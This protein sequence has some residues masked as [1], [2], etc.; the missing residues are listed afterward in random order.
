MLNIA[1]IYLSILSLS[2]ALFWGLT[3]TKLSTKRYI[4]FYAIPLELTGQLDPNKKWDVKLQFEGKEKVVTVSEDSSILET[5]EKEFDGVD[6]SCR[7]GICTTCAG[8]VIAGRE[9]VILAV[10]GLGKPQLEAGFVCTCQCFVVGPGVE[11]KLGAY[12]EVYETQY[13]QFE[14]SYKKET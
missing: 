10:N 4:P 14:R 13:G 8:K 2:N 3:S 12:D 5:G 6:S 7:N 9:N 11:I 1:L